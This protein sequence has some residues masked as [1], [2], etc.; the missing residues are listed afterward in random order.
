MF[1]G[2]ERRSICRGMPNL[3]SFFKVAAQ[4]RDC[5]DDHC[6]CLDNSLITVHSSDAVQCNYGRLPKMSMLVSTMEFEFEKWLLAKLTPF[7]KLTSFF[8]FCSYAKFGFR[9]PNKSHCL[10][11][12]FRNGVS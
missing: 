5:L 8:A 3:H 7:L 12:R 2:D 11:V 6:S 9:M 10:L 1:L 4:A